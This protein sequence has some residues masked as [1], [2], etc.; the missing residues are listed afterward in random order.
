MADTEK[1][2]AQSF[3]KL[4][5]HR[6]YIISPSI[7]PSLRKA[8]ESSP[9]DVFLFGKDLMEKCKTVEE[10]EKTSKELKINK[11]PQAATVRATKHLNYQRRNHKNRKRIEPL[12]E[13][14]YFRNRANTTKHRR[15]G[16]QH[17]YQ[18]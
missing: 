12:R 9:T 16:Y 6:K 4:S 8:V 14:K 10:I 3:N 13:Q 15:Q 5:L 11:K 1:L 7:T 18:N 2:I 17:Q